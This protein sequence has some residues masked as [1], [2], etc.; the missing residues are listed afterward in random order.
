MPTS[1]EIRQQM[2]DMAITLVKMEK[3]EKEAE[4]KAAEAAAVKKKADAEEA[5]RKKEG[6]QGRN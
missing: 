2:A 5:D 4:K 6:G 1:A 3:V